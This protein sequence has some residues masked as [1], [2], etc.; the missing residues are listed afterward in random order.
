MDINIHDA[1][2]FAALALKGG[3]GFVQQ[4]VQ[5]A[6]NATIGMI[7]RKLEQRGGIHNKL[8]VP[9]PKE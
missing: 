8:A 4:A 3:A 7:N 2:D 1:L 9:F 6:C 5:N